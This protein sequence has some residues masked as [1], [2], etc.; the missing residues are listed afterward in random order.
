MLH[1]A[2]VG[3]VDEAYEGPSGQK[4]AVIS[5]LRIEVS[6][7]GEL[8]IGHRILEAEEGDRVADTIRS[9]AE[10]ARMVRAARLR[11]RSERGL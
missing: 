7:F 9:M 6:R 1:R 10:H 3:R 4:V 5:G 11:T 8:R 2:T